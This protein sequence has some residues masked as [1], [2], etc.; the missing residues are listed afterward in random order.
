M[1]KIKIGVRMF[2]FD[3]GIAWNEQIG[4]LWGGK[5][6]V[7]CRMKPNVWLHKGWKTYDLEYF[8]D[9]K[10]FGAVGQYMRLQIKFMTCH[11]GCEGRRI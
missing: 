2:I 6:H 10:Q 11:A 1:F 9:E 7:L 3:R 5:S 8:T 4:C